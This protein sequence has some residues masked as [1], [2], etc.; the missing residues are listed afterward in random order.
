MP[1]ISTPIP[2]TWA[3]SEMQRETG[4]SLDVVWTVQW[5]NDETSGSWLRPV[6]R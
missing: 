1:Q 4:P 6:L 2:Y 5:S 3:Y